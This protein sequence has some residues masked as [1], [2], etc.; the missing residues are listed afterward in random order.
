M[1]FRDWASHDRRC[2]RL[3]AY[4]MP[5]SDDGEGDDDDG[6]NAEVRWPW[7]SLALTL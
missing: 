6:D 4:T 5:G 2:C 7:P 3:T 1:G